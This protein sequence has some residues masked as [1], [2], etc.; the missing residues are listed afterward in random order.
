MSR[1]GA[2]GDDAYSAI[3]Y[4]EKKARLRPCTGRYDVA[5]FYA[6]FGET[7]RKWYAKHQNAI[8]AGLRDTL[9]NKCLKLDESQVSP[10][11][12]IDL[13]MLLHKE[14]TGL[15]VAR[16]PEKRIRVRCGGQPWSET[17]EIEMNM[18]QFRF[19]NAVC[20]EVAAPSRE[21]V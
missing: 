9:K 18:R 3:A 15:L 2:A 6:S 16:Q 14:V 17:S 11:K 8:R 21:L 12:L 19:Y 13:Y 1:G 4:L 5:A 20:A 10:G 7:D